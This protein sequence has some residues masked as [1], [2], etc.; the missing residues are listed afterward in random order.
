MCTPLNGLIAWSE[1]QRRDEQVGI[2]V[3]EKSLTDGDSALNNCRS[4]GMNQLKKHDQVALDVNS[5]SIAFSG[6]IDL[7]DNSAVNQHAVDEN[8]PFAYFA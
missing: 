5:C 2:A 3:S 4:E 7:V 1:Q 8:F 6:E